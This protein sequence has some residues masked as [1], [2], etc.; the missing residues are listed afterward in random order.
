[1][2]GRCQNVCL[3]KRFLLAVSTTFIW[4]L[5]I[6]AVEA[7]TAN[8]ETDTHKQIFSGRVVS[9]YLQ[10]GKHAGENGDTATAENYFRAV[11]RYEPNNSDALFNLGVLHERRGD[12]ASAI[13][14]YTAAHDAA[15]SDPEIIRVLEDIE[16]KPPLNPM[17]PFTGP[18]ISATAPSPYYCTGWSNNQ[19][20]ALCGSAQSSYALGQ[21]KEQQ[22]DLQA[23]CTAYRNAATVDCTHPE[24]SAAALRVSNKLLGM[25][26][27]LRPGYET[28]SLPFSQRQLQVPTGTRPAMRKIGEILHTNLPSNPGTRPLCPVCNFLIAPPQ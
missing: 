17:L 22:G 11:L 24:Y 20:P 5:L 28:I 10:Q 1:M 6:N 12:L 26:E 2:E 13:R 23:A 14:F 9:D 21:L 27:P 3:L 18:G 16:L 8:L 7:Q 15:P 25:P 4:F 19:N